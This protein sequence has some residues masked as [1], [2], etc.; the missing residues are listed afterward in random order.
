[1]PE[2]APARGAGFFNGEET[3]TLQEV[4][5][6]VEGVM[7]RRSGVIALG[8]GAAWVVWMAGAI[9]LIT[10][11]VPQDGIVIVF[12][13]DAGEFPSG[14]AISGMITIKNMSN[15]PLRIRSHG[16]WLQY[17]QFTIRDGDGKDHVTG[18]FGR[19]Y[20][21]PLAAPTEEV[22]EPGEALKSAVQPSA[23]VESGPL[24]PGDYL[25]QA[26]FAYGSYAADSAPVPVTV[27]SPPKE[28]Q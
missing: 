15:G 7:Q 12:Q 6:E 13:V 20:R 27:V 23:V 9:S 25:V 2:L 19:P 14:E 11:G 4:P 17:L 18:D 3:F 21:H 1:M 5:I 22:I 28:G 24:T 26:R 16:S 8:L 10:A